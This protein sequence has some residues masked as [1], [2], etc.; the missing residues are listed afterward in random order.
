MRFNE[1]FIPREV[2]RDI[3]CQQ[4]RHNDEKPHKQWIQLKGKK[5]RKQIG[6]QKC[7]SILKEIMRVKSTMQFRNF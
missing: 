2:L 4:E 7:D 6:S 5:P 3:I 1:E